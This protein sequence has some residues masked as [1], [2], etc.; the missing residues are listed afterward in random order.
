MPT[1]YFVIIFYFLSHFKDYFQDDEAEN[2]ETKKVENEDFEMIETAEVDAANEEHQEADKD[3]DVLEL[4]YDDDD[5]LTKS[6]HQDNKTEET[7]VE[8]SEADKEN[9]KTPEVVKTK[10][11]W[12]S[13][14]SAT[15]KAQ[16]IRKLF[17][18]NIEGKVINIKG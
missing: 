13:G 17:E 18:E 1:K 12:I 10:Y 4:D 15:A 14:L 6:D 9:E 8:N 3:E 7:P 5:Q 11:L 16:E 2:S